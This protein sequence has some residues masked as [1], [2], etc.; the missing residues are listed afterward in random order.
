LLSYFNETITKDCGNCDVCKNPPQ[1]FDGTIIAQKALSAIARTEEQ[2]NSTLLIDILRG[3]HNRQVIEKG[4]DKIKT[5]G[6]GRDIRAGEWSDYIFQIL[7]LGYVD[8][9]YDEGHTFKLNALSHLV[10]KNKVNVMLVKFR[11]YKS[12]EELILPKEPPKKTVV[13]QELFDRLKQLRKTIADQ[14]NIPAYIV[15]SD[16]TLQDMIEKMPTDKSTMLEVSGVAQQKFATYG[17][18]FLDEISGFI[19]EE[20]AKGN[21][22]KGATYISKSKSS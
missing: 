13:N 19:S 3:S 1:K 7:N 10:L 15:F 20:A 17:Q 6:A 9:A 5:W 22:I 2:I 14:N 18:L 11:P 8:I 21:K 4:Y 12:R 16:K